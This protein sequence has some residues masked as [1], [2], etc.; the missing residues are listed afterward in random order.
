MPWYIYIILCSDKTLYTGITTDVLRRYQ[1]HIDL[2]GA[3]YFRGRSPQQLVYV[4]QV[5]DRSVASQREYA[6]KR[7][8][9]IEK[10]A[11]MTSEHNIVAQFLE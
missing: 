10:L 8:K 2:L 6:I 4:E 3:K 1:Q 5:V 7:L 9:R 11:L